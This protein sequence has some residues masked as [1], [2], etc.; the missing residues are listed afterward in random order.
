MMLSINFGKE[1]VLGIFLGLFILLLIL[2]WVYSFIKYPER[3]GE[4]KT[5]FKIDLFGLNFYAL[6]MFYRL[7]L[8]FSMIIF[9]QFILSSILTL[10]I[11]ILW[12]ILLIC[13]TPYIKNVRPISNSL[14]V[15]VISVFYL[16][17]RIL[18][19]S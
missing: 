2:I 7:T 17:A 13:K 8:S 16:Y 14:V 6:V 5:F 11:N 9:N 4:Y 1:K 12:A 3:F 15:I 10:V 19:D 18:T